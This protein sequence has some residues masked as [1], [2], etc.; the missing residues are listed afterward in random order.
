MAQNVYSLNVV[1][2]INLSLTNGL[3]LIANQL[4]LDGTM[5]NNTLATVFSTNLPSA[6]KV[7]AFDPSSGNFQSTTYS[8]S[9][10]KWTGTAAQQAF[11]NSFLAPG[12]GVFVSIPTAA[13]TP[14]TLTL[15]GEVIQGTNNTKVVAGL[16]TL[17][18]IPP[19]SGGV[20]SVLG[21]PAQKLDK[22][23]GW[24]P[25]TGNYSTHTY[26]G[27]T[28]A[29]TPAGEPA[30]AVGEAF[31]YNAKSATNWVQAFTVK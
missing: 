11:I 6:S 23:L 1:G 19:I 22:Y 12:S 28:W 26:N 10:Q 27:T 2:Y 5:T 9:S 31:F 8:A 30:P 3:N 24:S 4:D 17:S 18:A 13:A 29:G 14:I 21:F 20:V 16:Q 25:A 7:L 15:V